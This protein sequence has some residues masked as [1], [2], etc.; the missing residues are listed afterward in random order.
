MVVTH[1]TPL[2]T[3]GAYI[4]VGDLDPIVLAGAGEAKAVATRPRVRFGSR[5]LV[6]ADAARQHLGAR[7]RQRRPRCGP[8]RLV[9]VERGQAS[10]D[11]K[12]ELRR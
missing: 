1:T 4:R 8:L 7:S 11:R 3:T 2:P 6:K 9:G 12:R 5:D 10:Q